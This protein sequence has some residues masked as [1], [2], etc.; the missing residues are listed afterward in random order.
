MDQN[1]ESVLSEEEKLAEKIREALSSAPETEDA[2]IEVIVDRGVVTLSGR[3]EDRE[4][5]Q[6]AGEIAAKQADVVSVTNDLA[7]KE[8]EV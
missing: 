1:E 6:A 7:V 2:V 3:V 4:T 5:R 8:E